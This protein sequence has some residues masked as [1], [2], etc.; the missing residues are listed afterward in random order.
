MGIAFNGLPSSVRDHAKLER[1]GDVPVMLVH[2]DWQT[3]RPIIFWLHGRTAWKE[4]DPGRYSRYLKAGLACCAIDLPGHG[5]RR[6]PRLQSAEHSMD[7]IEQMVAELP[8]VV[9]AALA[10]GPFDPERTAVGGMSMGGMTALRACCEPNR[11]RAVAVEAA[12]GRLRDLYFP[13]AGNEIKGGLAEHPA[14]RVAANDPSEHM[15]GWRPIPILAVHA[16]RDQVVPWA[17]QRWFLDDLAKHY[18]ELGA[19]PNTIETL[20]FDRTGAEHE[21]L[22]FAQKSN[23]AKNAQTQFLARH[24]LG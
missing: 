24:L 18:A 5:Q 20:T 12:T 11:F 17:S 22:G 9:A 15:G 23:D 8:A 4:L 21:H 3:P 6:D 16:E 1:F 10:A 13:G 19:D 14:E 2:P 7:N